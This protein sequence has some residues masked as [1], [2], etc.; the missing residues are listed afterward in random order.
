MASA[1]VPSTRSATPCFPDAAKA[2]P[3]TKIDASTVSQHRMILFIFVQG[4]L[5]TALLR[6]TISFG[7]INV[8]SDLFQ[9][10]SLGFQGREDQ[11]TFRSTQQSFGAEATLNNSAPSRRNGAV[12]N[13]ARFNRLYRLFGSPAIQPIPNCRSFLCRPS[14]VI[15]RVFAALVF[16]WLCSRSPSMST[17]FSTVPITSHTV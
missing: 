2:K 16:L 5:L 11:Q 10:R 12:G 6:S 13:L 14:R 8:R 3:A 7:I 1:S 15:P 17:Y 4:L 9:L